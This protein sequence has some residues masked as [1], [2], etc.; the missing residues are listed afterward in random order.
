MKRD[1][2]KFVSRCLTCQRVK[3]EHQKPPGLLQPLLIPEWKWERITMDFVSG[4]PRSQEGY[5][6][7]WVIVDRLTK[8]AHF[9][10]VKV[11]YGFVK[12]AEIYVNEIVRLHGVPISIV[13]DRGPQFTS[14]VWVKF[15]EALGTNVQLSTAFHPQTDGQSERTIQILEDMLRACVID[16]GVGWSKYL[17]LVE[18]AYNNS[19]QASIDMAPYEALYGRKCRSPVCWYGVGER[20]LMGPELIQITSDKIKVIRDKLQTS[21]VGKKGKLSPRFIRPFEILERVGVVAYRLALPP[22]LSSIHPVFHVSMLRKYLSDSS[23]VLEVQP[24]ELREDM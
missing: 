24:V 21:S 16:F 15:Q 2:A 7:V 5:D 9:L 19:Y 6:S 17:S 1:I 18:F 10:P 12:L 14:R 8:S 11:T 3:G 13:F 20:R 22:N 23:H 4:L